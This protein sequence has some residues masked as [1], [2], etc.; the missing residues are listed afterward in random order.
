METKHIILIVAVVVGI[1]CVAVGGLLISDV[2]TPKTEI[3]SG[4]LIGTVKGELLKNDSAYIPND[5]GFTMPRNSYVCYEDNKNEI[6]YEVM[7]I[8]NPNNQAG[9]FFMKYILENSTQISTE[10]ING[11]TWNIYSNSDFYYAAII[12]ATCEKDNCLYLVQLDS[13]NLSESSV[14]SEL[15]NEF[16]IPFLESIEFTDNSNVVTAN[17]M[18]N[19]TEEDFAEIAPYL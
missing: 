13:K 17:E 5:N 3:N 16:L 9:S 15:Y 1:I 10:K 8:K 18:L 14:D 4:F 11:N 6:T 2:F 19:I 7:A 12:L